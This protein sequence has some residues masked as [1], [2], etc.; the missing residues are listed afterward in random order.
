MK[1]RASLFV[2]AIF[3]LLGS[4]LLAAELRLGMRLPDAL[5]ILRR[6]GMNIVYS[7]D[8]IKP[9]MRVDYLPDTADNV[10]LLRALLAPWKLQ[11]QEGPEGSLLVVRP[12]E[13][14]ANAE[15]EGRKTEAKASPNVPDELVVS[16]SRYQFIRR[17]GPSISGFDTAALES[18]PEIGDDPLRALARLPGATR[19]DFSA[20]TNA[21][22]G[23]TG[24]NLILLDGMRLYD[25]FHLK[26]FKGLFSAID[27]RLIESMEVY[28][29][30]YPAQYGDSMSSV[31]DIR[32][33][34][35]AEPFYGELTA[36]FFNLSALLA[37]N[38]DNADTGWL[39]S[40][41]R[42][43]LDQVLNAFNPK[44][45]DPR[46]FEVF[47]R[48]N[49]KLSEKLQLTGNVM[50]SKDNI[51]IADTDQEEF[52]DGNYRDEYYWLRAD[53][54]PHQRLEGHVTVSQA[55]LSSFRAGTVDKE[56]A[57]TGVLNEDNTFRI[58]T[59]S[60]DWLWSAT[61]GTRLGIGAEYRDESGRYDYRDNATFELLFLTPGA[62]DQ[63]SR[64]NARKAKYAGHYLGA[65]VNLQQ[66]I[67]EKLTAE[68]GIR[69][70]REGLSPSQDSAFD[71]RLTLRYDFTE[72]TVGRMSVGRY[73]QAQT[74]NELDYADG[75]ESF[76]NIQKADQYILSIEHELD[77]GISLRAE[78][79]DKHYRNL[80]PRFEN[81]LD[82]YTLLPQLWP[83]RVEVDATRARAKGMELSLSNQRTES[84]SWWLNY[85]FASVKDDY[86]DRHE[87][88]TW[89]KRHELGAGLA[90]QLASWEFSLAGVWRS[91]WRTTQTNLQS[92]MPI[93]L[94]ATG[95]RNAEKLGTYK[96]I[97]ARAAREFP[98]SGGET[99]TVFL[100]IYN[101][102]NHPNECC[103]QYEYT[104]E[105]GTF[106]Y[107]AD[108]EDQV[109]FFPSL[110]FIWQF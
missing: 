5:E 52:A 78:A 87:N 35:P 83:D 12:T 84:L 60:T 31:A 77:N 13:Y 53:I 108:N 63:V 49:H 16:A 72:R 30:G 27:S 37:G 19:N 41:R 93:P 73:S 26:G 81:F 17:M 8:L 7:S 18:E 91:G 25:P 48:V 46:Y 33:I 94:V 68:T 109:P 47:G 45:G 106:D 28:M 54:S 29:G 55:K 51:R 42:G 80:R 70:Q 34:N 4:P 67:S 39:L 110:G 24:E 50:V 66:P 92:T 71:P 23:S 100:E 36:S 38:S 101:L 99:L 32:S 64:A 88:R 96:R 9:G 74:V 14:V 11:L 97:D 95:P 44:L 75:A 62:P 76:D 40:A 15:K 2:C 85:S 98:L 105:T 10:E 3:F 61:S 6:D 86:E 20:R 57:A 79:Y 65:W 43:N 90:W 1:G 103:V 104:D 59:F 69:W 22:G 82:T 21:R 58:N 102:A 56:G 89:D 107:L